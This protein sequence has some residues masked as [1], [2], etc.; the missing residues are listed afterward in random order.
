M[1]APISYIGGK[2]KL[3]DTIISL[4][5]E[6]TTYC[7]VFTGAAW[8]FFKKDPSKNEVINDRDSDLISF[9]R[10]VQAHPEEFMK[11]FKYCLSS[12]EVFEDWQNQLESGGL[13][14]IQRAAR[15][16]YIQRLCFGGRVRGRTFGVAMDRTPRIN[17]ARFEEQ[18]SDVHFR[19]SRVVIEN[20]DWREFLKRYDRQETFFYLDPPYY[21]KPFYK[22]N[23]EHSDYE[24]MAEILGS[25]KGKWVL[26]ID[27]SEAIRTIFK[28]FHQRQVVVKYSTSIVSTGKAMDGQELIITRD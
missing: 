15:Y 2:F 22:H 28:P 7:E 6:H 4:I 27:N 11:Q 19:L 14:D 24:S 10:V 9:Y 5:P 1:R 16:Y 25:L 8:V 17:L 18:I 23:L 3:A 20:L 12:R 21:K 26:S 13:T